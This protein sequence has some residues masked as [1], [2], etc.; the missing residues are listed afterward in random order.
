MSDRSIFMNTRR[1]CLLV[2]ISFAA[3]LSAS[4][5]TV[6]NLPIDGPPDYVRVVKD[7][8]DAVNA[9][10]PSNAS[11]N[12]L[13]D[14][15]ARVPSFAP[16]AV[17]TLHARLVADMEAM[18]KMPWRTWDVDRQIDFRYI[19][20][21]AHRLDRRIEVEKLYTHR[22]ASW[23]VPVA[24][25]FI[26]LITYAPERVDIRR[27][28]WP[29][30]PSMVAEMRAV[31][32]PT[33]RDVNT[34]LGVLDGLQ[35]MLAAERPAP[36][37]DAAAAALD[38]YDAELK[39]FKDL[40]EYSVIGADAYA[41]IY[42]HGELLPWTPPQL[43]AMA[44]TELARVDAQMA[45]LKPKLTPVPKE[46]MPERVAL[47]RSLTREKLM[48]LYDQIS[49][50]DLEALKKSGVVT[51]PLSLGPIRARETP[52]AMV[53]LTG[54]GGSMNPPAPFVDSNVGWWNVEHF[55]EDWPLEWRLYAVNRALDQKTNYMGPYAAH[56]GVPGHHLQLSVARMLKDPIRNLLADDVQNEGWALYAEEV[57]Q[58]AGG[59]GDSA[60]ARYYTLNSWRHRVRRVIWDVNVESG[61]WTLQDAGDFKSETGVPGA[62]RVDEDILR[63]INAPTQLI[64]YFAGKME[65]L[66]LRADY[67]KKMGSAYSDRD[68][69][70]KFLAV[71]SVPIIFARAKLLGEPVPDLD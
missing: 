69:H 13:V 52:D 53:P 37:R 18:R 57:F 43:L 26:G 29:L 70:D 47:A 63:T 42:T 62:G 15:S 55:H 44:Q 11:G 27:K 30:I 45:E 51:V 61:Y 19:F 22:P 3:A 46:P 24:N 68:F 49:E 59:L 71:G 34:A 28:I 56:E 31:S 58:K 36:A 64:C 23:L 40:P 38:A 6:E 60:D 65:I 8:L 14:D 39:A 66:Q 4:G 9:V 48:A 17:A 21:I 16:E 20:S 33:A 32:R 12:G 1:L 41:W 5:I 7:V 2:S 67:K 10:D 35:K 50:D 25:N 54:D